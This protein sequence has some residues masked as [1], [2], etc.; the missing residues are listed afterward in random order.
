[1]GSEL[2]WAQNKKKCVRGLDYNSLLFNSWYQHAWFEL[3]STYVSLTVAPI[4]ANNPE[5]L[6]IALHHH[7]PIDLMR[8][9]MTFQ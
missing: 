9:L 4:I 8:M 6:I 3:D 1:M 7:A 2:V 5:A